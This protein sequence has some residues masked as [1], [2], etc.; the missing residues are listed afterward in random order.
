MRKL[1]IIISVL[2]GVMVHV[3]FNENHQI[4]LES[5][6]EKRFK[7]ALRN[8]DNKI[9]QRLQIGNTKKRNIKYMCSQMNI[10]LSRNQRQEGDKKM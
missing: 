3:C 10:I 8:M 7:T 2:T 1:Q 6:E 4:L 9:E 5:W